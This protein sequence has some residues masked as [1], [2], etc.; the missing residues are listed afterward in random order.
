MTAGGDAGTESRQSGRPPDDAARAACHD[1][2]GGAADGDAIV[3]SDAPL[4]AT[5]R[6]EGIGV[7]VIPSSSGH[8]LG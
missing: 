7:E 5:A 2:A 4:I 1:P 6:D 3:T 8:T